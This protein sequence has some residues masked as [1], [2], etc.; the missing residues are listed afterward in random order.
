MSST[1]FPLFKSVHLSCLYSSTCPRS[2]L[3][4]STQVFARLKKLLLPLEAK[5]SCS[6]AQPY[7]CIRVHFLSES[8]P[9]K[10][11]NARYGNPA[12]PDGGGS[13]PGAGVPTSPAALAGWSRWVTAVAARYGD[14]TN[15]W[16]IWNEPKLDAT[17]YEPYAKL[18]AVTCT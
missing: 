18:A 8:D 15:E 5:L 17:N 14:I 1:P 12:Y 3:R 9:R 2:W 4:G 13:G 16:E 6:Q 10:P 7:L 11:H